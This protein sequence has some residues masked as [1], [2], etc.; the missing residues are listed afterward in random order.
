M[1]RSRHLTSGARWKVFG[2][3]LVVGIGSWAV[4]AAISAVSFQLVGGMQALARDM[5]AGTMPLT[6]FVV[7]AIGQSVT[8]CVTSVIASA[9]YIELRDWKDG[10]RSEALAEVFA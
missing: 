1:G 9:L 10:P 3:S 4:G 7:E 5:S 2:I 6:Y 8:S